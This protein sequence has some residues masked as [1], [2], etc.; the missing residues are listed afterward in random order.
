MHVACRAL[1]IL[2]LPAAASIIII[3]YFTTPVACRPPPQPPLSFERL[4]T[5]EK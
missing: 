1:Y 5:E 3:F 4:M 2:S